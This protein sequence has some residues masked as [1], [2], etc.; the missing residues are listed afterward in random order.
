MEE[1]AA[2]RSQMT[3]KRAPEFAL[4]DSNSRRVSLDDFRGQWLVLYFYP[5]DDT[6]GCTCQATEFTEL[7]FRF[8]DMGAEVVGVSTDSPDT[9]QYFKDKHGLKITLLSDPDHRVMERYGAWSSSGI[10]G[11]RPIRTTV[12]IGPDGRIRH[13][14]PEVIPTGH[15]E[16]VRE[17]LHELQTTTG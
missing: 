4:L 13:H 14:W 5:A 9:H 1:A 6:P 16:R 10:G 11:G 15:A 17:K 7:L 3:G 8:R 12:I 2:S